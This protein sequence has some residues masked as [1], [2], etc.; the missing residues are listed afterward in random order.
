VKSYDIWKVNNEFSNY[1]YCVTEH[2]IYTLAAIDVFTARYGLNF[3]QQWSTGVLKG[4]MWAKD[5]QVRSPGENG[6]G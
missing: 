4:V 2:N 1:V 6:G 3:K 5:K